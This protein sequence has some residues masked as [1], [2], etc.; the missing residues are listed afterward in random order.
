MKIIFAGTPEISATVLEAL[1]DSEHQVLAV[2]TQPD[3]PKGRGRH[4]M[5]SPVKQLAL[6][7][8]IPVEQPLNFKDSKEQNQLAA[9]QADLMVVVAY[10][11][12]LPQTILDIPPL[13]CW[14]IHVSLLPRWRGAAPIQRAIEAGDTETGVCIM[15]MDAGLDT[16][17]ILSCQKCAIEPKDTAQILHDRLAKLGA[18]A[19]IETLTQKQQGILKSKPQN[20]DGIN[21]AE[22]LS[23]AEAVL[24]WKQSA[25]T[26]DCKVRAFIPFPVTQST[27]ENMTVR[28]HQALPERIE[29]NAMP[30]QILS[31]DKDGIRVACKEGVLNIQVIQLPGKKPMSVADVLNSKAELFQIGKQFS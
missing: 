7:H 3:R 21:Y 27:I 13:G 17:D 5:A 16:G 29:H 11:L 8:Q 10:G 24:N 30:G 22:K 31:A 19:L 14:N 12:I 26:L 6:A 1:L 25:Q 9:Y 2:Y 18:K 23:K 4:L 15:Q 28:I 20:T